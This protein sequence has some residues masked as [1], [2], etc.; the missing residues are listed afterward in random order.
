MYLKYIGM[1]NVGPLE[2]I[3]IHLSFTKNS[4]PKP[5]LFVGQNG[6]GKTVLLAQVVDAM[7]EIACQIYTNVDINSNG[8]FHTLYK[9]NGGNL[10]RSGTTGGFSILQ[11]ETFNNKT[12]EYYDTMGKVE[13]GDFKI[14]NKDFGLTKTDSNKKITDHNYLDME[15]ENEWNQNVHLYQP[16][17]RFEVEF[18]KNN[19]TDDDRIAEQKNILN[20]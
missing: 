19:I 12:I 8:R 3:S 9:I 6:T 1:R 7:Y 4:Q 2:N 17:H 13:S 16:A 11:F 10:L 15:F 5:I 20:N 14:V 18:W